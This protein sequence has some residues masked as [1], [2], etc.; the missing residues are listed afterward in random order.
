MTRPSRSPVNFAS[1]DELVRHHEFIEFL[2]KKS[3]VNHW[4]DESVVED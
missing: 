2:A 3:G 1:E 4:E